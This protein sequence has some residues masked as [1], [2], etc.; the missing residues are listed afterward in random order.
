MA[1][2]SVYEFS[3]YKKFILHWIE[4][5]PNRGRG[6]RIKLA[7]ALGCQT[8]F[9]THVLSGDYHLSIEQAEACSRWL[10]LGG[11]D[12][13]YFMLLVLKQRSS[14][15]SSSDFFQKQLT[16]KKVEHNILQKRIQ[17]EQ[18]L[19]PEIQNQYYSHWDY[20]AVH[21]AL[22]N[23]ESRTA[24]KLEVLLDRSR[25]RINMILQFLLQAKIIEA[26][27]KKG[28]D[29]RFVVKNSMIHL[30]KNS[31]LLR[32]HHTNFRLKAI[33]QIRETAADQ[34]HYSGVLSLSQ[35]DFE[36]VSSQLA[37]FLEELGKKLKDSPDEDLAVLNFDWFKF[38]P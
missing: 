36:W 30:E 22:L 7:A 23:P 27:N 13:E 12:A 18:G 10:G 38:K 25:S 26:E 17:V 33:D 34:V 4:Q 19:A 15:K 16:Q 2:I 31:P 14:T 32:Q 9:I 6:Q 37:Q 3:D 28:S 20:A 24:E 21:M 11:D 5:T 29:A 8:P 1:Y 35:K